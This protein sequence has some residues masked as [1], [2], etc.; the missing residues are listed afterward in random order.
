MEII[1]PEL[2]KK[3]KRKRGAPKGNHNAHTHGIYSKFI[4]LRDKTVI[5]GMTDGSLKDELALARA[6]LKNALER[7]ELATEETE[8]LAWDSASHTWVE[9]IFKIK[10]NAV[11][12]SQQ[13]NEVW[14]TFME[15]IRE[16]NDRQGVR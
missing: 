15:A 5:E 9:L 3:P 11:E 12:K 13:A 1:E 4:L 10:V 8:K 6:R 2:P 16:A 7:A 14:D